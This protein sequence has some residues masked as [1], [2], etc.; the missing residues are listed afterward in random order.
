MKNDVIAAIQ[1]HMPFH[2]LR[3]KFLTV[4]LAEQINPEVAI[5]HRDLDG[6]PREA[7]AEIGKKL[8]E[9][10]LR[11]TLHAPFLDLRPGAIDPEIRRVT[12]ARISQTLDQAA[13]FRPASIV[14]HAA[15]DER[16]YLSGEQQWLEN[17]IATF[18]EFLPKMKALNCPICIENV[19]ETEPAML[20]R[21]L[22]GLNSPYFRFC[23]DTGHYNVFATAPV[24][25]WI[26]ALSPYLAQLHIHDND[27]KK[28]RHL[29]P[30]DGNF[31][32]TELFAML[33]SR[34]LKPLVTLE[35]HS[36]ENFWKAV[37][38]LDDAAYF[39]FAREAVDP[40]PQGGSKP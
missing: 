40:S 13:F 25:S 32:F 39:S 10:G 17:C 26:E 28:D 34:N 11:I 14:C 29:P 20:K 2:F 12:V 33:R 3:E 31:P 4:V 24:L 37:S 19:Y 8:Q 7:F 23:F 21:L 9:A 1:V 22:D 16:Y 27:G 36:V 30:G 6:Y 35:T 5:N 38:V 18:H 15:F